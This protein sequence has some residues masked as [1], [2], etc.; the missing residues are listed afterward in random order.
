MLRI[1]GDRNSLLA[2][3]TAHWVGQQLQ[4]PPPLKPQVLPIRRLSWPLR[5]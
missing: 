1:H 3:L 5:R 4:I 2:A